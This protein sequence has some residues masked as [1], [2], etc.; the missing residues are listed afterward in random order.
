M[1]PS[2]IALS[3]VS[4]TNVGKT[5]L[6]RT[7]LG[8]DVGV[9]R[10][11]AHVT[12]SAEEHLLAQTAAGDRL[13]L[14]DT[15]GFGN[16]VRL[17][18]RLA[19]SSEPIGWMLA[20]VWDRFRDRAFWTSQ[21]AVRNVRDRAD[22][23][24]YLVD[25]SEPPGQA[26]YLGAELRI[27]EWIGKPV[28]VLLNQLGRPR[29]PAEEATEVQA[30]RDHLAN[31]RCV[32]TV[33]PLD[34]FARCW[35]QEAT[36]LNDIARVLPDEKRA[37]CA[38]LA[39]QWLARRHEIFEASM[40]VLAQRIARAATDR[41]AANASTTRR[42]AMRRLA[43]R[44]EI[45]VRTGT[46]RLIAL[47]GL[48]G[49]ASQVVLDRLAQNYTVTERLDESKAAM[50]G[51]VVTGALAG[52]KADLLS[53][54]LTFGAGMLAGGIVGALGGFGL[55]RGFN[56]V[57]GAQSPS[58]AWTDAVLDELVVTALLGYLA[59]AHY[60]RGRGDWAP[61]EHPAH[62]RDVVLAAFGERRAAFTRAWALRT[63]ADGEAALQQR[64]QAE[65]ADTAR[66]ILAR[67]YPGALSG[68]SR[69][70]GG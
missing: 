66:D 67:L 51:G 10:D 24:L 58:V 48:E 16:S 27:L 32:R 65:L 2:D 3:L 55:A 45:D 53:G 17:A 18:R 26:G 8:R 36:L 38:R 39:A 23:V 64:L 44:L 14:W 12:E 61:S 19:A 63:E 4:H 54:G 9:V 31:T 57:R 13:V 40:A 20:E 29:A 21:Q 6:A 69:A 56:M 30:W 52:L 28:I 37:A 43:E 59:V 35:V 70:A 41:E 22:V 47:H 5:T 25:A 1:S 34:A 62:W 42:T 7:L 11:E 50:F 60:G 15:P 68:R 46:D 33:L 49:R